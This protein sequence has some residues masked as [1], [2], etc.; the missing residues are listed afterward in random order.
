G[1]GRE[2]L[3][4]FVG[5]GRFQGHD[6]DLRALTIASETENTRREVVLRTVIVGLLDYVAHD[7]IPAGV[8]LTVATDARR[9][10][11][12]PIT[13]P[14]NQWV[15]SVRGETW[16]S[17]DEQE[18]DRTLRLDYSADRITED[19]KITIGGR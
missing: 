13:D 2:V 12:E 16:F 18:S 9:A 6:H 5:R 14:W 4:R 10:T 17:R 3:L 11:T 7:G 1:G 19:W 8:S 15:F